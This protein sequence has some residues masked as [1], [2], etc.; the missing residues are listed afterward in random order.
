M[1]MVEQLLLLGTCSSLT[2]PPTLPL[3][4]PISLFTPAPLS[5]SHTDNTHIHNKNARVFPSPSLPSPAP[6]HVS[7]PAAG[8]PAAAPPL[9]VSLNSGPCYHLPA[10]GPLP[11]WLPF[12]QVV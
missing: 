3:F 1:H 11:G 6:L 8:Y 2:H 12:E 7:S 4:L 9:S 5:L 10:D